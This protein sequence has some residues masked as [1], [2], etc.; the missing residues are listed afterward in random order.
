MLNEFYIL[1]TDEKSAAQHRY[2]RRLCSES[3][4]ESSINRVYLLCLGAFPPRIA[5][6][7][8]QS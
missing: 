3:V 2:L 5:A 1:H 6:M 7:I 4:A 8:S